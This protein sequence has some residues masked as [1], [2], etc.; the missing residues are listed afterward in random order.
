MYEAMKYYA[1]ILNP[2]SLLVPKKISQ[3]SGM[4]LPINL[5]CPS[6]GVIWKDRPG[7]IIEKY[8]AWAKNYQ[9]NQITIVFDTMWQSTRKM[10]EAIAYGISKEL[11]TTNIKICNAAKDDKNDILTEIFRSKAILVGS[12]TI[13]YGISY[14]IAG[15]L[16][17]IKGLKFK[18]KIASAFGSYGWSGDAVKQITEHLKEANFEIVNDGIAKMWMPDN[19]TLDECINYGR[20]FAKNII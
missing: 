6:H 13:N 1:N 19:T 9:E 15:L 3:L 12:P 10:A 8:A 18:N 5:I 17:M 14:A 11:P 7:Q 20:D 2:Y 16:E 4:N